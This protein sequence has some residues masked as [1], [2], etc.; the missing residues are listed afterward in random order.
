MIEAPVLLSRP[1]PVAPPA[2][3]PTP[4]LRRAVHLVRQVLLVLPAVALTLAVGVIGIGDRSLWMDEYATWYA[5]TLSA[6][7]LLRLLNHIDAVLAPYYLFMHGWIELFGDSSTSLRVPSLLAMAV[8]AAL[9]TLIGRRMFD[10]GVGVTAGML[11]AALPAVSRYG[12]EARPYAFAIAAA[13]LATLLLLRALD[14]PTWR[15]WGLYALC[16]TAVGLIHLVAMTVILA[17]IVVMWRAM[18]GR[19]DFRLLRWFA[20]LGGAITAVL[21]LAA[22]GSQESGAINWIKADGKAVRQLPQVVFGSPT[23]AAL[24]I[25]V[26]LLA[27]ALL[28]FTAN[29]STV[30]L[31]VGWAVLPPVFCYLTFP[32]LHFFLHRYLLFTLPAWV[33]LAAAAGFSVARLRWSSPPAWLSFAGAILVVLT[34]LYV[35][36]PGQNAVRR[37]PVIGEPD[38][39]GAAALVSAQMEPGD[40]ITFSTAVRNGRRSFAYEL[41]GK[42]QPKD[43]FVARSSQELGLYGV[44]ECRE[45]GVCLGDT[46]RLWLVTA[47][48]RGDPYTGMPAPIAA[49]LRLEFTRTEV[50]K[51]DHVRV[52]LLTRTP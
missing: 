3:D 45:P 20:A 28:W 27:A 32:L 2:P 48:P 14:D 22:K 47:D 26:A 51:L 46:Q 16:V 23:V 43:V 52:F 34:V 50:K 13:V 35:G 44:A 29:R 1:E 9:I 5:S 18:R 4:R 6:A 33:L 30:T 38:F 19:T 49:L 12:Q 31:L 42:P 40:G 21:P 36:V 15:R 7:D 24:V 17:H 39:R 11:F 8:A 10:A 25:G 37:D 41:R